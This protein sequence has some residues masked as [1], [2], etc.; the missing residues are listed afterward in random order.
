MIIGAVL[1]LALAL[2]CKYER[3]A[4]DW[5]RRHGIRVE[6]QVAEVSLTRSGGGWRAE[7][8]VLAEPPWDAVIGGYIE[9]NVNRELG[10]ALGA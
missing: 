2:A 10:R 1:R 3:R 7:V 5:L 4:R 9:R 8:R 6:F